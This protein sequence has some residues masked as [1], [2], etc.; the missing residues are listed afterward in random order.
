MTIPSRNL[1]PKVHPASRAV[2]PDD[3]FLLYA[4]PVT[5]DPEV[6]LRCVVEDYGWMGWKAEQILA[7]FRD[8]GYPALNALRDF[9]GEDGIRRRITEALRPCATFQVR[10][11][12]HEV[13]EEPEEEELIELGIPAWGPAKQ[14]TGDSHAAG[15]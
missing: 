12:M 8:P 4:T 2:E 10:V 11:E 7:L 3:P 14:P 1:V 9:Y 15:V 6:M 5:G 13:E